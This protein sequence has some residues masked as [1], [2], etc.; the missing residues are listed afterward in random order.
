MKY[1]KIFLLAVIAG[2][3]LASCKSS[4]EDPSLSKGAVPLQFSVN[5][6]AYNIE[7]VASDTLD[8]Q[9]LSTE[10]DA[11]VTV[12]GL[13][14]FRSL[15]VNGIPV[16]N[17]KVSV[18]VDSISKNNYLVLQGITNSGDS[19]VVYLRT[20]HSDVPEAA[21][22]GTATSHGEFYLSFVNIR[23]IEKL[24]STGKIL[25]YRYDPIPVNKID[26]SKCPG[27]WDFKKHVVDDTV[28]YSYH[29]PDPKFFSLGFAGYNPGMR[30]VLDSLY[31]PI[32]TFQLL[33]AEDKTAKD[34]VIHNG[35]PIDGHDFYMF[36]RS[37]YIMSSYIKRLL[38]GTIDSVYAAYLQEVD[39]GKVVFDW[40][41]TSDSLMKYWLD[42]AFKPDS[43]QLD[44]YVHF[45][46]IDLLPD[47]NL[48]CSFRHVSSVLKIE[49]ANGTGKV[50][51]RIAGAELK[52][53]SDFHG[54]HYVR[55][56]GE[57]SSI[58]LFDNGNVP[59]GGDSVT[60]MLRFKVDL[61]SGKVSASRNLLP[62]S[63]SYFTQACGSLSFSGKNMVVG[64]GIPS[65]EKNSNRILSEFDSSGVEV[66]SLRRRENTKIN[67][68]L[69]SYRSVKYE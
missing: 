34:V 56:H 59:A 38:P 26:S 48:L 35:D 66:F 42:P 27:W 9:T 57:D 52:N 36:N 47:N 49:R 33:A 54:Q 50:L 18:P 5:G 43:G 13:G 39:R 7:S 6:M 65:R 19:F 41:S 1:G 4:E 58:T 8:L 55:Y 28:F 29:A 60:K 64:W 24:D 37:H 14:S 67:L 51:W 62:D 68:Y 61:K 30:I 25:F 21:A 12:N 63:S 32:D 17:G 10:F 40:W 46:S 45:N 11:K 15:S 53:G 31:N 3:V 22:S 69:G 23:L 16:Q 20:L 44:D 2:L